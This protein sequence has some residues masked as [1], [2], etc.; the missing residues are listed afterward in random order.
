MR[1]AYLLTT[2]P[3]ISGDGTERRI[4]AER[5]TKRLDSFVMSCLKRGLTFMVCVRSVKIECCNIISRLSKKRRNKMA[6]VSDYGDLMDSLIDR[7][8]SDVQ[9]DLEEKIASARSDVEEAYDN[10]KTALD[11][12]SGVLDELSD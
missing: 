10:I 6:D 1:C 2:S 7:I 9:S 11:L 3:E 8:I 12:L 4:I 5:A